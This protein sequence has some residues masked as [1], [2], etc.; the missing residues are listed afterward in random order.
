MYVKKEIIIQSHVVV[1]CEH[2]TEVK[3][4]VGES[5]T[6]HQKMKFGTIISQ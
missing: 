2:K 4:Y 6:D 1:L 5:M 3:L